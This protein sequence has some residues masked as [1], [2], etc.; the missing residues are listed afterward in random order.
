VAQ[1]EDG[2]ARE[3]GL[4]VGE[5]GPEGTRRVG[6][7]D[8]D[9]VV[10][11]LEDG[12]TQDSWEPPSPALGGPGQLIAAVVFAFVVGVSLLAAVAVLSWLLRLH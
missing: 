5:P 4:S 12:E 3:A 6:A 11:P 8:P 7:A 9:G 2:R 10:D 1:V